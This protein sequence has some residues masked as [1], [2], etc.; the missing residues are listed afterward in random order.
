MLL[1]F[2]AFSQKI[3]LAFLV[4]FDW[5]LSEHQICHWEM[6]LLEY[7]VPIGRLGYEGAE[8]LFSYWSITVLVYSAELE[9]AH[10]DQ[11]GWSPVS[12]QELPLGL[13]N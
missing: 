3:Y 7:S 10:V 5:L 13:P 11:T 9:V 12:L 2:C 4:L 1:R 6:R 8:I